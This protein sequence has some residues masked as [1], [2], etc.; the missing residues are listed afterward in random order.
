MSKH[1]M[2]TISY[3]DD[4]LEEEEDEG[5]DSEEQEYLE[6][7]TASVLSQL[8]EGTDAESPVT[9]SREEVQEALWH[10]YNDVGKAVGYLRGEFG[11]LPG[12]GFYLWSVRGGEGDEYGEMRLADLV[13]VWA[14]KKGKE[15]QKKKKEAAEVKK[16]KGNTG[17]FISF[18]SFVYS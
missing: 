2:K 15:M 17:K 13:V 11:F 5:Y 14:G 3:D 8:R 1:R 18:F 4:D 12:S 6:Q 9:A 7:C 16:A 10:Y